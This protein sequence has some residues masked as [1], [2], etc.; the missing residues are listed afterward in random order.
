MNDYLQNNWAQL[1]S[2]LPEIK[3]VFLRKL[4]QEYTSKQR[5]YHNLQHIEA[6]L[7]LTDQYLDRLTN[8]K[9]LRFAIWYHDVIYQASRSDNEE[10]SAELAEQH[11]LQL[12]LE[13]TIISD[14]FR[15]I[16]ATKS[17]RLPDSFHSFDGQFLLDIDL[18][19]LAATPENYM[20]YTQQIR[21]EYR[22]YPNLM[23]NKGRKKVLHH[24]LEMDRIFVTDLC[25]E[26][27]ESKARINLK[28]ELKNFS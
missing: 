16:V 5:H 7:R 13:K 10:K 12:G 9:T 27:Y 18:S 15:M 17:H 8:P 14:V 24:F 26:L 1:T 28:T 4:S 25:F 6:L 2:E 3:A 20:V 22:I 11:L 21:K 19:I 23:Y